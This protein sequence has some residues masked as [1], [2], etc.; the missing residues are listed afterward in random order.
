M[1]GNSRVARSEGWVPLGEDGGPAD[2]WAFRSKLPLFREVCR[3]SQTYEASQLLRSVFL[4]P[5][6]LSQAPHGLGQW[7][8]RDKPFLPDPEATVSSSALRGPQSE[9]RNSLAGFGGEVT[10]VLPLGEHSPSPP[11]VQELA[12]PSHHF[13]STFAGPAS[14][15]VRVSARAGQWLHLGA[16]PHRGRD[17]APSVLTVV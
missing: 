10:R 14:A 7:D 2:L 12:T 4:G 3:K 11:A 16:P 9:E 8:G 17:P 5:Q 1:A 13:T 6:Q 15:D